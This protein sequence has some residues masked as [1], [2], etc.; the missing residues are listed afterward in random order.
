[1][2]NSFRIYLFRFSICFEQPCAHHPASQLYQYNIWYMS[3]RVGDCPACRSGRNCASS[4]LF[5]RTMVTRCV[6]PHMPDFAT[7]HHSPDAL[8]LVK[9]APS[10]H[11]AGGWVRLKTMSGQFWISC[12]WQKLNA[13]SS[14]LQP[15]HYGNN[16]IPV[17]TVVII[18]QQCY[19]QASNN[20]N[21]GLFLSS[22]L[23]EIFIMQYLKFSKQ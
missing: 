1:M 13:R 18:I 15:S 17:P 7:R 5:I 12:P 21:I 11:Q 14:S 10:T 20:Q 6:T 9:E 2:H 16:G 19:K 8:L 22:I 3:L 4:W 23:Y